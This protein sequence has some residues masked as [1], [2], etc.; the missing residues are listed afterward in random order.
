MVRLGLTANMSRV[1]LLNGK[2][3]APLARAFSVSVAS[4]SSFRTASLSGERSDSVSSRKVGDFGM[5]FWSFL[6]CSR[7]F[8]ASSTKVGAVLLIEPMM[9]REGIGSNQTKP[10]DLKVGMCYSLLIKAPLINFPECMYDSF[11][12]KIG[13]EAFEF[14]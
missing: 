7:I 1:I 4:M 12:K 11:Q 9:G 14:Q 10:R 3:R 5:A 13:S 6:A 2:P 8:S